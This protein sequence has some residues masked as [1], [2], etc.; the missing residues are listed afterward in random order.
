MYRNTFIAAVLIIMGIICLTF[1]HQVYGDQANNDSDKIQLSKKQHRLLS[2]EMNA[3]Q[4]GMTV[5]SIAIPAGRWNEIDEIAGKMNEGYI[6]KKLSSAELGEFNLALPEG[7]QV[8]NRE[9]HEMAYNIM[10]AAK[11]RSAEQVNLFFYRL[12][13]SC[14]Q[15][16]A[17]YAKKRFP[18]FKD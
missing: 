2:A 7:Y 13:E 18:G 3:V 8:I 16:H 5:L 4:K 17:K 9:Y 10:K 15:C 12:N 6:M 14:I 1:S 11:S